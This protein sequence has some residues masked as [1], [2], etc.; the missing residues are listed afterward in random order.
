MSKDKKNEDKEILEE[1]KE[2]SE[3]QKR[4]QEYL[5]KKAEEEA[6]LA[7]EK[8]KE[9]QARMGEES[10][11]SEDKQDQ[12]SETD[13]EDSESAKEESEEKVASSEADKEKEEKEEIEESE[14]KEKEEQDKK[15]AKKAIK[16]KPAKAKIPGIHIL[17]AFTI[18]FPSL[19][20]L[21][22]SAYLLSPYATMKDIRVE[23]TVQ[24]T[25]DDIRQASGIQDSDYTI[26]LLLDKAKYEKQIKSN[27]WVESAQLVYQ[28]PTKFTIKV[29]EYDIVAYYI[30]G[31]NH[32]PIL[33]SG[34]LETSSVSLN[35]LPET[36][37][38]VLFNDSE[39]IK[40]FVSELA[41]I[42]PEL[43]AA[44]Q[45]VELAPSKVTSDLIRL[46]M[47]DSD[48][49][50]VPLSEM[51]KKLPYY[52]KIK[53]QLSEPS[54]VDMEAGIYSYTVADKLIME[55]EEKAKQEAK[56]AEKKQ[57]EEQKRLEEEQKK[58]EEESNRNQ[59]TQRS[60]RR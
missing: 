26:N 55:A 47:N 50:L 22:V 58:Q 56:E 7:E 13:Q 4:N 12:E 20:L 32:Y 33:S 57:E 31:E 10:E 15:L 36:Y 9:R 11:K 40:A 28:F 51:S 44:I 42:S 29:K 52:S 24:T 2:L 35:S 30:S 18:L 17:R 45:K 39:Q 6:A 37:L 21:I 27:Y 38:S 53:P 1:L 59:T 43:K 60:S 49:V 16:E 54:V 3:W 46:T 19:L 41:Q 48:E 34:Q 14:S 23:G 8:E 25:A 5:K